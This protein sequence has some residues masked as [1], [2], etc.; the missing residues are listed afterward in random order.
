[1]PRPTEEDLRLMRRHSPAHVQ[2]KA[3]GSVRTLDGLLAA[4]ALGVSQLG[5][6]RT[7]EILDE[8][9]QRRASST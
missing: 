2:V 8:L 9:T 3:A 1:M 7:R 4:R 6:S 5:A